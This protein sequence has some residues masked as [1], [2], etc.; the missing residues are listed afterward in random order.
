MNYN[1]SKNGNNN[2]YQ[3]KTITKI[4]K[5]NISSDNLNS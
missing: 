3:L 1:V 5:Q 4:L 2:K